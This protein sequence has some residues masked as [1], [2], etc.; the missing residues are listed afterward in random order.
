MALLTEHNTTNYLVRRRRK[1]VTQNDTD[2]EPCDSPHSNAGY[3]WRALARAE[4]RIRSAAGPGIRS[5]EAKSRIPPET[6]LINTTK[7][8]QAKPVC[9]CCPHLPSWRSRAPSY[10]SIYNK[11]LLLPFEHVS[12][13]S[14]TNRYPRRTNKLSISSPNPNIIQSFDTDSLTTAPEPHV[15]H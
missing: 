13:Y 7:P 14:C 8:S 9:S 6:L 15:F 5:D 12:P 11:G 10:T 4:F 1:R 2:K 3:L